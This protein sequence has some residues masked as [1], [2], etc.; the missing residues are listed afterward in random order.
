MHCLL[1]GYVQSTL[2]YMLCP[3]ALRTLCGIKAIKWAESVWSNT[4]TVLSGRVCHTDILD[5]KRNILSWKQIH[6][7]LSPLSYTAVQKPNKEA[8]APTAVFLLPP[9]F[10]CC[11]VPSTPWCWQKGLGIFMYSEHKPDW[12]WLCAFLQHKY[13]SLLTLLIGSLR[14]NNI[15]W[16]MNFCPGKPLAVTLYPYVPMES[17][18]PGRASQGNEPGMDRRNQNLQIRRRGSNTRELHRVATA[19]QGGGKGR[20]LRSSCIEESRKKNGSPLFLCVLSS[21]PEVG[22]STESRGVLAQALSC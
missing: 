15:Y 2:T 14:S 5:A 7:Y 17:N 9:S 4:N 11:G 19:L 10:Q 3:E 13:T 1:S 22:F 12:L 8:D 18:H 20:I 16:F 6:T 21:G